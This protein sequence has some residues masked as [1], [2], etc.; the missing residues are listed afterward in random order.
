MQSRPR[1]RIF[2]AIIVVITVV[3][4]WASLASA[5]EGESTDKAADLVRQAIAVLVNEP[6]NTDSATDK[7]NDASTAADQ[8]GVDA[9]QLAAAKDALASGDLHRARALAE[10][11]IGAQPHIAVADVPPIGETTPTTE[12]TAGPMPGAGMPTT[13][14]ASGSPMPMATG[15]DPGVAAFADPLSVRP[16]LSGRDWAVIAVSIGLG[17]AGV[18]LAL[19]FRPPHH[20]ARS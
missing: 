18:F 9:K 17:L 16:A 1:H 3:L 7:L 13:Q 4:S 8:T 15:S 14:V 6:D 11:S 5:H 12:S 19:R 20:E 2:V 10:L